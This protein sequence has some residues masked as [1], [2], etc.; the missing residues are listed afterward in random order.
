[1]VETSNTFVGT[2]KKRDRINIG[3]YNAF[4]QGTQVDTDG[5]I[6]GK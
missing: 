5:L 4:F 3:T 6:N 2:L 1:M